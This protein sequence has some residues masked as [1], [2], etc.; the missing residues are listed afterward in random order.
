MVKDNPSNNKELLASKRRIC[1]KHGIDTPSNLLLLKYYHKYYS[2]KR[3]KQLQEVLKTR[4]VR[5][6]SG[7]V[8]VS[9]LTKPWPCPG[10]CIFCPTEKGMPKSYL[11]KEPAAQRAKMLKFDPFV[12]VQKRIEALEKEGHPTQKVELRIIGG[13]WSVYQKQYKKNFIIRCFQACNNSK[14]KDLKK[15]QKQNEKAKYRI[16]G[17]SIETRPDFITEKELKELREY[18]V[19]RVEL[20]VQSVYDDILKF[21]KRGNT[22]EDIINATKL[23][24]DFGFKVSYQM[25][26]NLP[27]STPK[28]DLEMFDEVFNNPA[29]K[30]D[31]LKIYPLAILE[32]TP[33]YTLYKKKKFK[34]YTKRQLIDLITKIKIRVPYYIRIQR[35][36]RD[37]PSDYIPAGGAKISNLRQY[38]QQEMKEK[39]LRCKCIRCRELKNNYD[40]KEKI[41]LFR[42]NYIASD[43]QEIFLS[44]ENKDRTKL[45]SLLRLRI[46]FKTNS[47]MIRELHTYGQQIKLQTKDKS[48]IQHKGLGKKLIKKAESIII[49]ETNL[50]SL[51]VISGVGVR[52]YY[53]K[54]GYKL[55]DT[56]MQKRL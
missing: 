28:R 55:K 31:Y 7:I 47:G 2:V 37:I 54:L 51:S 38:I 27:V 17:M 24:K 42:Y 21:V 4:P 35:I 49:K 6:L 32:G 12:Q 22:R 29:F 39:G 44:Y 23:L 15:L 53:R 34:P 8:N 46:P 18:G 14:I 25:M 56:Y 30:P 20:G 9:V 43:G 48:G 33:L 16:V 50:K 26:P 45:F 3:N 36:T 1:K 5:S 11:S 52:D 19:T 13:T 10:K 41:Y 40:P